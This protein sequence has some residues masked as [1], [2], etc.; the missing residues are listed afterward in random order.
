M[1]GGEIKSCVPLFTLKE[2][3]QHC[4]LESCWIVV[5]DLVYDVTNFIREVQHF[6]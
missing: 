4:D 5:S 6:S 2:V 1:E 3:A